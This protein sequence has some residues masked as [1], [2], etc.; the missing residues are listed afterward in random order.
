VFKV[1]ADR[2]WEDYLHWQGEDKKIL[3]L[4]RDMEIDVIAD[5]TGL[6]E[7]EVR[8]LRSL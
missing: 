4:A 3:K 2:A 5:L 6:S 7:D 8:R 1:W